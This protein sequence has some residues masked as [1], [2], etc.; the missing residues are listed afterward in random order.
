[1]TRLELLRQTEFISSNGATIENLVLL[2]GGGGSWRNQS[3]GNRAF[4]AKASPRFAKSIVFPH[5]Y[6]T[7]AID[8]MGS[9]TLYVARDRTLSLQSVAGAVV[10]HDMA[11]FLQLPELFKLTNSGG[12]GYFMRGDSEKSSLAERM[13]AG[14]DLSMQGNHLSNVTPFFQVLE[15]F[16]KIVTDRMHI[17]IAGAMLGKHVELFPGNYGKANA[18]FDLSL[19]KNYPNVEMKRW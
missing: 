11:F 18:V 3:S 5:T 6:E 9:K 12:T 8:P 16:E 17:A 2:S 7:H 13:P 19:K 10:C 14:V 1:M 15:S 4:M